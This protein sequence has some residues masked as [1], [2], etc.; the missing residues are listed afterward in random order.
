MNAK[1]FLSNLYEVIEN[2]DANDVRYAILEGFEN[3]EERVGAYSPRNK[4]NILNFRDED[5]KTALMRAS[6][7][8]K[9]EAVEFLIQ[10]GAS[11][12]L[13]DDRGRNALIY[14]SKSGHHEVAETL[15]KAKANPNHQTKNLFTPLHYAAL[16]NN[17]EVGK[18]LALYGADTRVR[19]DRGKY[20]FDL[21]PS[22][23]F[24]REVM[25]GS[26]VYFNK[27]LKKVKN[28]ALIED[29]KRRGL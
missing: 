25:D 19:N 12:D 24:R 21:N 1:E 2:G 16:Y 26:L 28:K 18:V 3:F 5:G 13:T 23:E 4:G 11:V 29:K 9:N 6:E 27:G 22:E 10:Y 8:G 20:A 15:L 17:K 14:A 7:L